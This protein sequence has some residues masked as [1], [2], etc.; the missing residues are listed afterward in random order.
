MTVQPSAAIHH[1]AYDSEAYK[2]S[3]KLRHRYLRA[4]LGL[5]FTE[6]EMQM[7][8]QAVHFLAFAEEEIIGCVIGQPQDNSAKIRQMVVTEAARG[9]GIGKQLMEAL[10]D[11]FVQAGV[12][13]FTMHARQ[14]AVRFYEKL[15]YR[16]V[17]E[18]FTEIGIPHQRLDKVLIPKG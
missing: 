2:S 12:H 4:P 10:E 1:V 11:Y 15:G 6:A 13:C 17:G 8:R 7:D 9:C 14:D 5:D 16:K 3:L 18:P